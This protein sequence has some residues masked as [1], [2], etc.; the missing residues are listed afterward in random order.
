MD[1]YLI[2]SDGAAA[3]RRVAVATRKDESAAAAAAWRRGEGGRRHD[4]DAGEDRGGETGLGQYFWSATSRL[5]SSCAALCRRAHGR[6]HPRP[7]LTISCS[8]R[9]GR[10]HSGP[11]PPPSLETPLF[12]QR[13]RSSFQCVLAAD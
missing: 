8:G 1:G 6:P 7:V 12:F 4:G 2:K 13:A 10:Y 5:T 9:H 3:A 11:G